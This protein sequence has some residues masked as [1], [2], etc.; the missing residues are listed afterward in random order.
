MK[1]I[2]KHLHEKLESAKRAKEH[3]EKKADGFAR[4]SSLYREFKE[5]A[6]FSEG[7]IRGLEIAIEAI[8]AQEVHI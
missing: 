1:E 6:Q 2:L 5:S 7:I 8:E 3:Y 4:G